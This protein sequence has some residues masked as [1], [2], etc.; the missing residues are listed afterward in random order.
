MRILQFGLHVLTL[1]VEL[2]TLPWLWKL[3]C[4]CNSLYL[5]FRWIFL[6]FTFLISWLLFTT[7]SLIEL[8]SEC[9]PKG[10]G[11]LLLLLSQ[12]IS[13]SVSWLCCLRA[14]CISLLHWML[15]SLR[16]FE[17]KRVFVY[18]LVCLLFHDSLLP[19]RTTIFLPNLHW[20]TI[21]VKLS[22]LSLWF[23]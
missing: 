10:F 18:F 12:F 2:Y 23:R 11:Y 20:F 8:L 22:L 17:G 21:L 5:L 14:I 9:H 13:L 6:I 16:F 3:G 7:I 1:F 4:F 19:Y 15:F